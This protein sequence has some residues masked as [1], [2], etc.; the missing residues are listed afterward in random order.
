[1]TRVLTHYATQPSFA[2]AAERLVLSD[3]FERRASLDERTTRDADWFIDHFQID[4]L[5]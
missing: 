2:E 1:M 3:A 5:R 4:A